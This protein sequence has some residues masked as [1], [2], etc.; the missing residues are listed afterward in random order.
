[1][2]QRA[3]GPVCGSY[4][5]GV[6]DWCGIRAGSIAGCRRRRS[7]RARP[8]RCRWW[9]CSAGGSGRPGAPV[10]ARGCRWWPGHVAGADSLAGRR[11]IGGQL[12]APRREWSGGR[13]S[14][15]RRSVQDAG[16]WGARQ[17]ARATSGRQWNAGLRRSACIVL[18]LCCL[19]NVRPWGS[20]ST[21]R[22]LVGVARQPGGNAARSVTS[23]PC[24]KKAWSFGLQGHRGGGPDAQC[25][26]STPVGSSVNGP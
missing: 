21:A 26:L 18:L 19:L 1:M 25:T 7:P 17:H 16:R 9:P 20:I 15:E 14:P 10:G 4:G 24:H 11:A 22:R 5:V 3:Q 2:L 12:S 6:V 23:W 13:S 8:G